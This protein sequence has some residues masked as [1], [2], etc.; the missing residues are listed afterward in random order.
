MTHHPATAA[1]LLLVRLAAQL[2]PAHRRARHYEEWCADVTGAAH[3]GLNPLAI[4]AGALLST[5]ALH[6]SATTPAPATPPTTKETPMRQPPPIGV[7]ATVQH[8]VHR[9]RPTRST[10]LLAAVFT[11]LLAAG[12]GLLPLTH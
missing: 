8:L 10:L 5:P 6:R 2:L 3:T 4:A 7:L 12:L 1:A 9:T 11:S